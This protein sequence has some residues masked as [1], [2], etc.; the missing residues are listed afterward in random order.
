MDRWPNL[1]KCN[2]YSGTSSL[3]RAITW[4]R[5]ITTPSAL[6]VRSINKIMLSLPMLLLF[7]WLVRTVQCLLSNK[8]A[9]S[10]QESKRSW[11][12]K[13]ACLTRSIIDFWTRWRLR[14]ITR[15]LRLWWMR[16]FI[17]W[18]NS[19]SIKDSSLVSLVE[20]NFN[21]LVSRFMIWI[22]SCHYNHN[23]RFIWTKIMA[24][25]ENFIL[26]DNVAGTL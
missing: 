11:K 3:R 22:Y 23:K 2:R 5:M 26:T 13:C 17:S 25:N 14:R 15:T 9:I 8:N 1:R 7:F 19:C 6:I 20:I 18:Q 24:E 10:L 12:L 16:L 4:T 21:C